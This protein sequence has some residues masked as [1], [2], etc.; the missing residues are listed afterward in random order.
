MLKPEATQQPRKT[1]AQEVL[2]HA[3]DL[4]Q[5]EQLVTREALS[6]ALGVKLSI[7]DE[8]IK[9][10]VNNGKLMRKKS[11]VFQPVIEMPPARAMSK[12]MLPDGWVKI[13]IGDQVL[14]LTPREDRMLGNLMR[15]S[16]DLY[17]QVDVIGQAMVKGEDLAHRMRRLEA[18]VR[19]DEPA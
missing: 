9:N 8:H 4:H 1:S 19:G 2:D 12:T 15:G 11:G 10:L 16:G 18:L 3:I 14:T 17:A 6:D 5:R 7:V 13:E